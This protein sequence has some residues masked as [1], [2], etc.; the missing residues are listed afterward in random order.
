M[1]AN[2]A[3]IEKCCAIQASGSGIKKNKLSKR[4][5]PEVDKYPYFYGMGT[6][7]AKVF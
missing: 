5:H 7:E 1:F 3:E 6:Y 4:K 2:R